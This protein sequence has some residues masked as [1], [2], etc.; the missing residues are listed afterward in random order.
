MVKEKIDI[1]ILSNR[2]LGETNPSALALPEKVLQFGTGILLRGLPDF[3]IHEANEQGVFNGRVVMVKSTNSGSVEKFVNQDCLYTVGVRG[4]HDGKPTDKKVLCSS[5]GRLL[6]ANNDWQ[7]IIKVA[8]SNDLEVILSNTTEIGISYLEEKLIEGSSPLSF[9]GK[10]LACLKARYD[11]FD[12]DHNKGLVILPTE[13][14]SNN[15]FLLR[16][17]VIRLA[18]YN[19][20][21]QRFL[22]W[23][24][25]A[26]SF[27][28]TLVDRIVPGSLKNEELYDFNKDLAYFDQNPIIVEPYALWAIEGSETVAQKLSFCYAGSGA[29]VVPSIEKYK[30]LKLRI[31]NGTHSFIA[32]YAFLSGFNLVK[33]AMTDRSFRAKV[34][35]L[36]FD[37]II[38]AMDESI[39]LKDRNMFARA[40]IDRFAN[41]YLEHQWHAICFNYT[42]KMVQ[43]SIPLLKSSIRKYGKIPEL[44]ACGLAAMIRFSQPLAKEES[45][46][47]SMFNGKRYT[48]NDPTSVIHLE[49]WSGSNSDQQ[50]VYDI[51]ADDRLWQEDL[52]L[53][54]GL[55]ETVWSMYSSFNELP[56]REKIETLIVKEGLN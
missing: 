28:N 17:I 32:G 20:Y 53:L 36:L 22:E 51:L 49:H 6:T 50:S 16:E 55:K 46:F 43:R 48:L 7:E 11:F 5:I 19:D 12:G 42:L 40:V 21:S 27:C 9:P 2:F 30:E 34:E 45:G 18:E 8:E 23:I 24:K 10:L 29:F 44:M 35:E 52:T 47:V 56:V 39:P 41:P 3:I 54:N 13:L 14:I 33:E 38:P 1:E 37:E 4:I 26:N 31:L 15:G 25:N